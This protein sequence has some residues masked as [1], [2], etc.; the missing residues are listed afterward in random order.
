VTARVL[1]DWPACAARG[2]C[3]E[4]L[5]EVID[6]DEWGYPIVRGPVEDDL[7]AAARTAARA[8]PRLAL[9]IADD[10]DD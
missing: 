1:V 2:V 4:L 10:R 7:V 3:R 5:P 6:L 8:C 9:R